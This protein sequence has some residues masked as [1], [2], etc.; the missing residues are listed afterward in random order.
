M[1]RGPHRLTEK[2]HQRGS[3]VVANMSGGERSYGYLQVRQRRCSNHLD[4]LRLPFGGLPHR[5]IVS[6]HARAGVIIKRTGELVTKKTA[7]GNA[8]AL[9]SAHYHLVHVRI[10]SVAF[11][12]WMTA[13]RIRRSRKGRRRG[14]STRLQCSPH[15]HVVGIMTAQNVVF[16][17]ERAVV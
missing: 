5:A 2:D 16:K 7:G 12:I 11:Q 14:N 1:I 3:G 17:R 6:E 9:L 8:P 13:I 10:E 15:I 4:P